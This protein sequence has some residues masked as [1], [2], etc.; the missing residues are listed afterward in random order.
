MYGNKIQIAAIAMWNNKMV[1]LRKINGTSYSSWVY[2]SNIIYKIGIGGEEIFVQFS[3]NRRK[4]QLSKKYVKNQVR[5]NLLSIIAAKSYIARTIRRKIE[6][7]CFKKIQFSWHNVYAITIL[8]NK[9]EYVR[10]K[11]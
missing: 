10:V 4:S 1:I 6:R 2:I 8:Y 5:R 11:T 7:F 3:S 9:F